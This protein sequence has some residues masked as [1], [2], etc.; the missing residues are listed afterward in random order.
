MIFD[1]PD[2]PP[3]IHNLVDD[4]CERKD[5]TLTQIRKS[6]GIST[7]AARNALI[8]EL[9]NHGLSAKRIEDITHAPEE[10]THRVYEWK[11]TDEPRVRT[12]RWG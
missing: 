9:I 5:L 7:I 4:F 11:L 6:N 12:Q 1:C 8:C 3:R 10:Y 2:E